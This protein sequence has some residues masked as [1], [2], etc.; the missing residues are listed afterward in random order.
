MFPILFVS[1]QKRVLF[2][3]PDELFGDGQ[4]LTP[5]ASDVAEK[6]LR[7]PKGLSDA[8]RTATRRRSR[9]SARQ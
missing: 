6:M 7:G 1:G 5:I 8:G 3:M 4:S 9:V 2:E